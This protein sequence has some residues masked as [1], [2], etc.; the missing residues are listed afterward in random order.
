MPKDP[1]IVSPSPPIALVG[2][3]S[4]VPRASAP[5]GLPCMCDTCFL[6]LP[7]NAAH[8][9]VTAHICYRGFTPSLTAA[10]QIS[11]A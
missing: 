8:I 11:L 5:A 3:A 1:K 10:G 9:D 7:R 4:I 2:V 6:N